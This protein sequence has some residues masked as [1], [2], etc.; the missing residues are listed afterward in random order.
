MSLTQFDWPKA[1]G[2]GEPTNFSASSVSMF[3]E[4]IIMQNV[5]T[6]KK[7]IAIHML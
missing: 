3:P 6:Q 2:P 1:K 5:V 4:P 7:A